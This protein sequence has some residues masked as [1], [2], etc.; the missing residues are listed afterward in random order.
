MPAIHGVGTDIVRTDRIK[1]AVEKWEEKFLNRIF[2]SG[3]ISFSYKKKDPYQSLS[4]RFAAKEAF[5]KAVGS[6]FQVSFAEIEIINNPSGKPDIC[7]IGRVRDFFNQNQL[8]KIHLSISHEREYA[9]AFV[10]I[11]GKE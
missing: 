9:I 10:L 4:A 11:E 5:I 1:Q 6:P 8:G 3:E 7:L 2:T